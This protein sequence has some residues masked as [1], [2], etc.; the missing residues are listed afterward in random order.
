MRWIVLL[1]G[2]GWMLTGCGGGA[3][4]QAPRVARPAASPAASVAITTPTTA[5]E[6]RALFAQAQAD[7]RNGD[8]AAA[9]QRF[10][11][12]QPVY[13]ELADYV[14]AGLARAAARSGDPGAADA[15]WSTLLVSE[16]RS[17]LVPQ[18]QLERG[19]LLAARDDPAAVG[20]LSAARA[21][22]DVDVRAAAALALGTLAVRNG[23]AADAAVQFDAARRLRPGAPIGRDA[24]AQLQQLRAAHPELAPQGPAL[25]DELAL[26]LR[27]RD[28]PAAR[29]TAEA[30]LVV[31]P[32]PRILRSRADAEHGAGDF[33][34]GIATLALI[35]DRYPRTPEAADAQLRMAT[36]LWNRDRNEDAA[37]A[38]RAYVAR[39]PNGSGVPEALYAL[40]RIDQGAGR[41]ADAVAG[42][43][44][45][46]AAAPG[47]RQ[48]REAR[49]RIGWIAYQQGRWAD[50][51]AAFA[52]AGNGSGPAEAPDA[53]YWRARS[54]E[55]AGDREAATR[56]YRALLDAAPGS[57]YAYWAEERLQGTSTRRR[58]RV[59]PPLPSALGAPPPGADA[60]HWQKARE[61]QAAGALGAAR[62]EMQAVERLGGSTPEVASALPAA[63]QAAGG[64]RDAI[65]LAGARGV[66][67]P[68]LLYP[69]AF[70]PQVNSA[71]Q[72]EGIDPLL[73][74]A[75]MRQESL[76]DTTA[77]SPAD[78][79]GLMQLLPSTAEQVAR[80]RGRPA[81]TD[82]LYDPEV[83]V[84]LGVAHLADL[85][86][87]YGG[88]PLKA[89]AAYNGGADAVA[90]WQQRFGALPGDEFVENITYRETR[91]YVKKV[92]GNYRRYQQ[93]YGE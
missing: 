25:R 66:G 64:Y 33:D 5:A 52:A 54:L 1:G 47:S 55:R 6:K 20:A 32:D 8:A 18:A 48:A 40:A 79:R 84:A 53:Y 9:R 78:A 57:Y 62:H 74:I 56:G 4:A 29:R 76:F 80:E 90:R 93:L 45:L 10:A 17:L 14:L 3:V 30:I 19:R 85:M 81:P 35:V 91:D 82:Q 2:L 46:I 39:Y 15:A 38:F 41:E 58:V 65:R 69:L 71:A 11:A 61:L 73:A 68:Q 16:P 36:L 21:S 34:A 28:Y 22:D 63:Y 44:R 67:S 75:L 7:L 83:N 42:Y 51:A 37:T 31:A 27:E 60:Y 43:R 26:L 92:M 86:R 87:Q 23:N 70:W 88:D 49:W 13:P 12:L 77:R 72:A 50:A 59:V 89:T 24:K